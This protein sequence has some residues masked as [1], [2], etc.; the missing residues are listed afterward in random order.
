MD[1]QRSGLAIRSF[2]DQAAWDHWLEGRTA[3]DRG[4]WLRLAK[5]GNAQTSLTKAQAIDAALIHGW[6]DG[7]L[8][9]YDTDWFL[10]RFTP[11]KPRS[12]WSARNRDRANKLIEEGRMK[13]GG[14]REVEAAK[15]DGRWEAAYAPAS[16]AEVP[17]DLAEALDANP[18][19]RDFFDRLSGNNR[20]AILYRV[21]DA[22]K[23]ETRATRIAKFVAMCAAGETIY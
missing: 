18:M 1:E 16:S 7:Q 3:A 20:Y 19:A 12:K 21:G 9:P 17:A 22:K 23:P 6:I 15:A 4:L 14:L 5:K 2:E 13:A 11:R 8:N 10:I